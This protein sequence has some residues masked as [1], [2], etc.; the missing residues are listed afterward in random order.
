MYEFSLILG[1]KLISTR[2][3]WFNQ[4]VKGGSI[5]RDFQAKG[6]E[7]AKAIKMRKHRILW[8]E[9]RLWN[10]KGGHG[11]CYRDTHHYQAEQDLKGRN[12][13]ERMKRL[14]TRTH[15]RRRCA[16]GGEQECS[17][18]RTLRSRMWQA[19]RQ[20]VDCAEGWATIKKNGNSKPL[21]S[22]SECWKSSLSEHIQ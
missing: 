21:H 13:W 17:G 1:K 8:R 20:A 5:Q 4:N 16:D 2:I 12:N 22:G 9:D 10:K 15:D 7:R 19:G 6:T 11:P 18:R 14:R 3:S